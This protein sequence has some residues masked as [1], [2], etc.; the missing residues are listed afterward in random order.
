M[1]VRPAIVVRTHPE[2]VRSGPIETPPAESPRVRDSSASS[3]DTTAQR[4]HGPQTGSAIAPAAAPLR[5]AATRP[6][7]SAFTGIATLPAGLPERYIGKPQG[8]LR[9]DPLHAGV[10]VDASGQRYVPIGDRYYAVRDDHTGDTWR[11]YQAQDPVK[12]E[13][14]IARDQMGRWKP[15]EDTGLRGGS[16]NDP[17]VEAQRRT[18]EHSRNANLLQAD[19]LS[20]QEHGS[21]GMIDVLD[22]ERERAEARLRDMQNRGED[23][24]EQERMINQIKERLSRTH[25]SLRGIRDALH[26]IRSNVRDIDRSLSQLPPRST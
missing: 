20:A 13:I 21:L 10:V 8:D 22:G 7:S 6:Q 2:P 25:R 9:T 18:L 16:P 17:R 19:S 5:P 11:V 3:S 23:V 24:A 1:I 12:P 15:R 26:V 14:L 4:E